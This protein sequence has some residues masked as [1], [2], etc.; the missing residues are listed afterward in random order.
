[1]ALSPPLKWHGGKHYLAKRIVALFPPHLHYIEPYAGGLSVLLARD[2]SRDWLNDWGYALAY[3]DRLPS[4]LRGCSEVVNDID[5]V[6]VNFWS[7]LQDDKLFKKF[8]KRMVAMPFSKTE[9]NRASAYLTVRNSQLN[10][11]I[12][13][14]VLCRQSLAGRMG[15]FA[16]LSKTRTRRSMNEQASAWLSAIEGLPAVHERL[17][18]VVILNDDALKVIRQQ[19]G[20]KTLFYCDPPYLSE[21]RIAKDVYRHEMAGDDHVDLLEVLT[22]V[23][24]KFLLSGYRNEMYDGVARDF[25]WH[26]VDFDLPNHAAGGK[27]K[28]RMTE[29]VWM[30]FEPVAEAA[31]GE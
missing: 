12:Y 3:P 19:D 26:R 9:Y 24:G 8:Q 25:K 11:A 23:K 6:L 13:F 27:E 10:D 22:E 16:P 20:E 29:C 4:S 18:S 21:T 7:V 2:P 28:R 1:M 5:G 17:K 31:G 30:N 15:S 14:F